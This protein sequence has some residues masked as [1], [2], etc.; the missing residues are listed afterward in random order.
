M[1]SE[2]NIKAK[3]GG[4]VAVQPVTQA[5]AMVPSRQSHSVSDGCWAISIV[6]VDHDYSMTP[7]LVLSIEKKMYLVCDECGLFQVG[8]GSRFATS[9]FQILDRTEF[10][11]T[12]RQASNA[13]LAVWAIGCA[14][15]RFEVSHRLAR[16]RLD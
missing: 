8:I 15:D 12:R 3:S 4:T 14:H 16:P 9:S 5:V 13:A 2:V 7:S 11:L 10:P 1:H 6:P